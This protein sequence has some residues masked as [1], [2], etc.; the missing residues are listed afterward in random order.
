MNCK[1]C[2][3]VTD[4]NFCS[5]CG[6]KA[7]IHPITVSH[8]MHDFFHAFTHTD[9]GFLLTLKQLL[10]RPGHVAKEYI[11]GRRKKY[12]NP[13][14]FLVITVAVS[15]VVSYKSGY[16]ESFSTRRPQSTTQQQTEKQRVEDKPV[17]KKELSEANQIKMEVYRTI[18]N[19]GKIIGLVLITPLM[20]ILSWIFFRKPKHSIAEHFVLQ[21]YLFGLSNVYRVVIFIPVLLLSGWP[22]QN[23]DNVFQVFFLVYMIIGFRQFFKN[24]LIFTVLKSILILVLFIALFWYSIYG[25]VYAKHYFMKIFLN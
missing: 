5:N 22:V 25:Y 6:Q 14:S 18:I 20:A 9:K 13:L 23:I 2:D 10:H 21:S 7:E 16:F 4:G 17:V 8:V 15:A 19:D 12:F 3:A 1:N 11:E 24:K